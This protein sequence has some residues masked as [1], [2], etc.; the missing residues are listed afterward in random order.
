MHEYSCYYGIFIYHSE[1][2]VKYYI[3]LKN[4]VI[5][6]LCLTFK[7]QNNVDFRKCISNFNFF[8][9]AEK[10]QNFSFRYKCRIKVVSH[11]YNAERKLILY[12]L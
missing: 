8:F 12:N 3:S 10:L 6:K 2:F 9:Y 7:T 11:C 1:S 4:V 5:S